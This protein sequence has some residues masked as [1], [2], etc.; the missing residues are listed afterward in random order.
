MAQLIKAK[1]H[2]PT[3]LNTD[4]MAGIPF[5]NVA[6]PVTAPANTAVQ[7]RAFNGYPVQIYRVA[8]NVSAITAPVS[9]NIVLNNAAESGITPVACQFDVT[10]TFASPGAAGTQLFA[11]DQVIAA[12][13]DTP[14]IFNIPGPAF[15][16]VYPTGTLFTLRLAGAGS[17]T[18][19]KCVL[20]GKYIDTNLT[21]PVNATFNPGTDVA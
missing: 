6:G 4:C 3:S 8:L 9:F 1:T 7:A 21:K 12:T 2:N 17:V 15:D 20:K 5:D 16:A 18:N 13:A 14:Q 11:T 19:L 10:G